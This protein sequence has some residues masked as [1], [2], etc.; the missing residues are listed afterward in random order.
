LLD[1][2][3]HGAE[4]WRDTY[5][6]LADPDALRAAGEARRAKQADAKR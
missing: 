4:D 2:E 1:V 3:W 6:S 5:M